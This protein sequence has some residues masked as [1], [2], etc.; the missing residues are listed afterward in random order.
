MNKILLLFALFIVAGQLQAQSQKFEIQIQKTGT[1]DGKDVSS[2]D[3]EQENDEMD[4]LYD[5]DL[6]AG[7]EGDDFNIMRTGLRFR[8]VAVPQGATIDS[9]FIVV[10]SHEAENDEAKITIWGE[11]TDNAV[12]FDLDNLITDRTSTSATVSWTVTDKWAIWTEFRTPDISS[13]IQEIVNRSGWASG[14]A[15]AIVLAGEDQGASDLDNA[16]DMMSFENEEDPEDGGDGMNHP[17]RVPKLVVYYSGGNSI[18]G[19]NVHGLSVYPNPS[20]NGKL[21]VT[22]NQNYGQANATITNLSGQTILETTVQ[23]QDQIDISALNPG[24]Y[25]FRVSS[26]EGVSVRSFSVQ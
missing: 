4:K 9:A 24:M 20:L 22:M 2:D 6:D 16:R 10:Y 15:L 8:D 13:I 18:Q 23:G 12:T 14:N 26:P 3:A 5:D 1:E 21:N 25:F 17:D 19:H 7:W 11:A